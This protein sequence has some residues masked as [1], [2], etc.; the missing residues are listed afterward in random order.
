MK[1][2]KLR[3][4]ADVEQE[5]KERFRLLWLHYVRPYYPNEIISYLETNGRVRM[6]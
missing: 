5:T 2:Y 3:R 4:K 6:L 1:K